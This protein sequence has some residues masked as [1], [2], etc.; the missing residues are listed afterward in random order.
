[1][2]LLEAA[3]NKYFQEEIESGRLNKNIND[4]ME[5]NIGTGVYSTNYLLTGRSGLGITKADILPENANLYSKMTDENLLDA[6]NI[7][8]DNP[9]SVSMTCAFKER[10]WFQ[11]TFGTTSSLASNQQTTLT[12]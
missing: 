3:V 7:F 5:G 9:S 8:A 4:P 11:K 2:N 6:L 12:Q 10:N 1:M